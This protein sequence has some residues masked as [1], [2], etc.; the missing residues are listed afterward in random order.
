MCELVKIN[1]LSWGQI[2]LLTKPDQFMKDPKVKN[3][4]SL[5]KSEMV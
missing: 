1:E 3:I 4:P 5:Y 2:V